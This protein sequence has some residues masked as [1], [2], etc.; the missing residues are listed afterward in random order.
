V[1]CAGVEVQLA[2]SVRFIS[3]ISRMQPPAMPRQRSLLVEG[4]G[5]LPSPARYAAPGC[6]SI[7]TTCRAWYMP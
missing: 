1:L 6:K 2:L 3:G 7:C 5:W 4:D